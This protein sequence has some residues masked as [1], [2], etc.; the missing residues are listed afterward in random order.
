M[1]ARAQHVHHDEVLVVRHGNARGAG[2][3][4][5]R[6]AR[7]PAVVAVAAA[8]P[9]RL[10]ECEVRLGAHVVRAAQRGPDGH[11][12]LFGVA[13]LAGVRLAA[14]LV[15]LGQ[16]RV[17]DGAHDQV[18]A[19]PAGAG[20]DRL[21][22]AD[23]DGA[24]VLQVRDGNPEH[25]PGQRLLA[26]D[27]RHLVLEQNVHALRAR[28]LLQ[29]PHE[30][31]AGGVV[32]GLLEVLRPGNG[33][34]APERH[35][36]LGRDAVRPHVGELHAVGQQELQ[37]LDV[38]VGK[39]A[40]HLAVVVARVAMVGPRVLQVDLI[41]RILD[42]PLLLDARAA[43][44]RHAAL[45][46]DAVAADVEVLLDNQDRRTEVARADGRGHAGCAGTDDD[47][48]GLAVPLQ[49]LRTDFTRRNAAQHGGPGAH[50][51][52][53]AAPQKRAAVD[54][55]ALLL[56]L[57]HVAIRLPAA[58]RQPLFV[59]GR[60]RVERLEQ[61]QVVL[62]PERGADFLHERF[63]AVHRRQRHLG[64]VVECRHAALRAADAE[65]VEVAR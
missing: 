52:R 36:A 59:P 62:D 47:D 49:R 17:V 24:V 3:V 60:G 48:I 25:A 14:H 50:A 4:E 10:D 19:R 61:R 12:L 34:L 32:D 64:V 30:A 27:A 35:H 57:S 18:A 7:L 26:D 40:H 16:Q 65:V 20:N 58:G 28:A 9:L 44:E 41:G 37:R 13:R 2:L 55:L 15:L 53:G 56:S 45:A 31:G 8:E 51:G 54:S 38:V 33:S 29:R 5:H 39:G 46:D 63:H 1:E 23:V 21:P 42:A 43:A 22:R 6:P 11:A